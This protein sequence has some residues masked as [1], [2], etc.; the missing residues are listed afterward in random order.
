MC[1]I[2]QYKMSCLCQPVH[3][4]HDGIMLSPSHRQSCNKIHGNNFPFPFWNWQRLQQTL[5]VLMLNLYLLTFHAPWNVFSHILFHS[6]PKVLLSGYSNCLLVSGMTRIRS[7]TDFIH[8]NS[9][10]ICYIGNINSFFIGNNPICFQFI[11]LIYILKT[12][13]LQFVFHPLI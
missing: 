2:I 6:W 1:G 5:R 8:N 11:S 10:Q 4:N 3:H 7:L 13:L 12:L 9:P